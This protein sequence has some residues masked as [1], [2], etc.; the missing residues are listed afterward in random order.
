MDDDGPNAYQ[1]LYKRVEMLRNL[2]YDAEAELAQ[3]SG[4]TAVCDNFFVK[5]LPVGD[6]ATISHVWGKD[7][8]N[9]QLLSFP[10][11]I[12]SSQ[13]KANTLANISSLS[14]FPIWLD[15]V[16][17]D[18][19][20]DSNKAMQV[21]VMD[22]TYAGCE[23]T[24]I[25][26]ECSSFEK[27]IQ[28]V[29]TIQQ[30]VSES[31]PEKIMKLFSSNKPGS[32]DMLGSYSSRVWTFQEHMLSARPVYCCS[33]G[34]LNHKDL[35]FDGRGLN[36]R[37][38][39]PGRANWMNRLNMSPADSRLAE[40][41]QSVV[42]WHNDYLRVAYPNRIVQSGNL[43]QI[44]AQFILIERDCYFPKDLVFGSYKLFLPDITL[45]YPD[46][47]DPTKEIMSVFV[48][49]LCNRCLLSVG[50][51]DGAIGADTSWLGSS[52]NELCLNTKSTFFSILPW[53]RGLFSY[54]LSS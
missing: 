35:F 30:I 26:L 20:D 22:K 39:V 45:P 10:E 19:N 9:R 14:E 2:K 23:K 17:I 42:Q 47:P 34:C 46:G 33:D 1:H 8:A 11:V 53:S 15:V 21:S 27:L 3:A 5:C 31:D 37:V 24:Y 18:Q 28:F 52:I 51:Q 41:C 32:L 36:D 6:Y 38:I 40:I 48:R 43:N 4:K 16:S 49:E 50:R 7:T 25:L 44:M 13:E 12:L 29:S 54:E